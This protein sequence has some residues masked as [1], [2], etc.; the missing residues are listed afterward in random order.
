MHTQAIQDLL[1]PTNHE[2]ILN[3]W[4]K[5]NYYEKSPVEESKYYGVQTV[6]VRKAN[7]RKW[8]WMT[9]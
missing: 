6:L 7:T 3:H 4:R 8:K 1:L 5:I 2:E 9:G